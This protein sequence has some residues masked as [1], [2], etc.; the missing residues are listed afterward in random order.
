MLLGN[1]LQLQCIA[2]WGICKS[3]NSNCNS[4]AAV[5]ATKTAST[6]AAA[7]A[8]ASASTGRINIICIQASNL[9]RT[10]STSS[11]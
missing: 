8:A 5:A 7:A 4:A 2:L 6:S 1:E 3:A 11:N 9:Q 10:K